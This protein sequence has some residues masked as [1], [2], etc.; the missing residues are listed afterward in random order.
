MKSCCGFCRRVPISLPPPP[1]ATGFSS[2]GLI[3]PLTLVLPALEPPHTRI[4]LD[5]ALLHIKWVLPARVLQLTEPRQ[6][7]GAPQHESP[8]PTHYP[9]K[10]FEINEQ[11]RSY[12]YFLFHHFPVFQS[13]QSSIIVWCYW[14]WWEKNILW[15]VLKMFTFTWDKCL[16][17]FWLSDCVHTSE[18][19]TQNLFDISTTTVKSM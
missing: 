14:F 7:P 2:Q 10:L 3:I 1:P 5:H 11:F 17:R 12:L 19:E 13:F 18:C 8:M 9:D 16:N 15:G 6:Q 4:R